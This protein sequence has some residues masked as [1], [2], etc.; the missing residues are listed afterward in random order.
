MNAVD[1]IQVRTGGPEARKTQKELKERNLKEQCER[2]IIVL[3]SCDPAFL[4]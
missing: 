2:N 4:I 3:F 1:R